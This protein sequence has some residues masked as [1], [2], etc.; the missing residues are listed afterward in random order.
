MPHRPDAHIT[1]ADAEKALV[2][3]P[4]RLRFAPAVEARFEADTGARRCLRLAAAILIG[5]I[6]HLLSLRPNALLLADV[7]TLALVIKVGIITPLFVLC[8]FA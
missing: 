4:G 6:I 5:M 1:L 3:R 8:L 2:V 7:F